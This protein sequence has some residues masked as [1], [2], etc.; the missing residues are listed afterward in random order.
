MPLGCFKMHRGMRIQLAVL[1]SCFLA[2][3]AQSEDARV[4][5]LLTRYCLDCHDA[6]VRKADVDL[7]THA[8]PDAFLKQRRI[9]SRAQEMLSTGEMPPKKKPQPTD[10][11]R[12]ELAAWIRTSLNSVDWEAVRSP[13]RVPSARLTRA[14]YRYSIEDLFGVR[15]DLEGLLPDDPEGL[16]GFA[17]DRG[18]LMM[19]GKQLARYL[20]TAEVVAAAIV[21][22]GADESV[23]IHYEVEEGENVSWRKRPTKEKDGSKGWT[24]SSRLGTKYQSISKTF[25]FPLTGRYRVHMRARSKGPGPNAAAW[26]AVDSVNDA[27]REAGILV[28]GKELDVYETEI[29]VTRG[30]HNILFGYDFYGSLWLPEAPER[31]QTKLGQST[32]HP[33]PY[34][35]KPLLPRGVTLIDLNSAELTPPADKRVRA[36]ELVQRINKGYFPAVLD[37][38]MMQKFHYEKGYLPVF[39]GGLSYEY[40]ENIVPALAELAEIVGTERQALEK[41]W[42]DHEPVEY[43]ELTKIKNL[44][45]EA[46][47]K[48]EN[49]RK[50][51]IGDLFVDW[52]EMEFIPGS[53]NSPQSEDEL[54]AFLDELL[55]RA[56]RRQVGRVQRGEYLRVYRD[57]RKAGVNHST[58]FERVLMAILVSPGFL[59]RDDGPAVGAGITMLDDYA[60]AARLAGFL[61]SSLPDDVLSETAQKGTLQNEAD[62]ARQVDRMLDDDRR[63][64]RLS[65]LFISQWLD[66]SGIGREKEPDKELFRYFSWRL[67]EDMRMEPTLMFDRLLREDRSILELLDCD[68]AFVNERLARIYDMEGVS[69]AE[70]RPVVLDDR[71]RGGVLGTAAMLSATSL[72]TR[73]SP[74]RRGQFVLETLLDVYL[75]PPPAGVPEL[76]EDA[77]ESGEVSSRESLARHR[78][79]P[80]CSSCHAKIDPL[81]FALENFDWIGRWRERDPAGPV[82]ATGEMPDGR[83]LNGVAGLKNYLLKE[84]ADDFARALTKALL[85]YALGRELEYFDEHAIRTIAKALKADNYR[86]RTL[87]KE[88][89]KSYPFRY[90][91]VDEEKKE[92]K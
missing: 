72:A 37:H 22:G 80:R 47:T 60:L 33:P 19:T 55:P 57:E 66:L 85:A 25:D 3:S 5:S 11:E 63:R 75:P 48:Q 86:A 16:S 38:L 12:R 29:F 44:Q 24:F 9:W 35:P 43:A 58:A 50:E 21:D 91:Q 88:I 83:K 36:T 26:I 41:I 68:D 84:R 46:W 81:G 69:G 20:K 90:R 51:Q 71:R 61:W 34:D 79:D 40:T 10:S 6:E 23:S 92:S 17:N 42:K 8:S 65:R 18:S 30:Q 56:Y 67:A 32:F 4:D 7:S 74:V 52:I 78:A 73:T 54:V 82:N 87:V 27:S 62:L 13:G 15:I 28:T 1:I 77:G 59:Y 53:G 45:R 31:P 2:S 76:D 39:L 64:L 89:I 49:S 14:E 70:F